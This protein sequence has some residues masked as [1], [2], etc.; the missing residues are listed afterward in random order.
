MLQCVVAYKMVT[1][2]ITHKILE[3]VVTYQMLSNVNLSMVS[4]DV[5]YQMLILM[6]E[7]HRLSNGRQ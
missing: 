7:C 1:C 5:C 4:F 3:C 6:L 2:T